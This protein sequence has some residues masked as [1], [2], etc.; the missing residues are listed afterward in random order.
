MEVTLVSYTQPSVGTPAAGP[1]DLVAY[2]ARVSSKRE[3][4]K[5]AEN[6]EKLLAYF[7]KHAHW[8]PFEMVHATVSIKAPRDITRQLIRHRSFS[9]QEFSQRYSDDIETY[10]REY[11]RQDES[12]RQN[13][14]DD[15]SGDTLDDCYDIEAHVMQTCLRAYDQLREMGV[16]KEC[17]RV[18]LPEGLTQSHLYMT[19][20]LRSWIHYLDLRMGEETQREHRELAREIY[21]VLIPVFPVSLMSEE[22]S[23]V[24]S[25]SGMNET[26]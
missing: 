17:A 26:N 3:E 11:R 7:K 16:A 15:F 23:S 25:R 1:E 10:E 13:S 24:L 4:N 5:R 2:S 22:E 21:E 6:Y 9:F 14:F 8:S 12:N 19:G 18:V 20:S